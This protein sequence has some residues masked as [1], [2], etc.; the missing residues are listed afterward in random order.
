MAMGV[1]QVDAKLTEPL[2]SDAPP[3]IYGATLKPEFATAALNLSVDF[4]KQQSSLLNSYLI[5]HPVTSFSIFGCGLI[6]LI[7]QS[8][9]PGNAKHV[10]GWLYQYFLMNKKELFSFIIVCAMAGSLLLTFCAKLTESVFKKKSKAIL[11]T[12]GEIVY[13]ID[14]KK[15]AS[16]EIQ[17]SELA[18]NTEIIVYRETPI[19]VVSILENKTLSKKDSLVMGI[20]TMG[21][22]RVYLKSGILEDLIDW[23]LIRTKNYQKDHGQF[24]NGESMKL[25]VDVYSF[26]TYTR[27]TLKKKG[28]T[29]I[30]SY[31]MPENKF[32]AGLFGVKKELWG[33]QFHF[34]PKKDV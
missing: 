24:K 29:L 6:Y 16:G 1:K 5:W 9:Y 28:F 21:C 33:V 17:K 2:D 15:L 13:G 27:E 8:S 12:N 32:L 31:K 14:L 19:A 22:R 20:S 30:E 23:A 4:V 10:T 18:E 3:T 11:E 34:E 26:E 7:S 25:L